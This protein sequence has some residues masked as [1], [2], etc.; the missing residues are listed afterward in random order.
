VIEDLVVEV[1]SLLD[2][3]GIAH[4]FGGAL[5]LNF[6]AE[7][8]GTGSVDVNL[9]VPASEAA[10]LIHELRR[11]GFEPDVPEGQWVPAAGIRVR[12]GPEVVD[13]FLS[14]DHYHQCV[15]DNAVARPLKTNAGT[16]ELP[17]LSAN[18]L[19][20]MKL[21]FNRLKDWADIEAILDA[22][23]VIDTDYVQE[24]LVAFRGP[25]AYPRT[26]RL[27]ALIEAR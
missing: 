2:E 13:L 25:T 17:F 24:Q 22:G 1:H 7:P 19:V 11:S 27:R 3:R 9:A 23:T 20:V 21:S 10:S 4:A 6:Y 12:R 15:L 16:V 8:R 26:A 14:F 5:A 18:D